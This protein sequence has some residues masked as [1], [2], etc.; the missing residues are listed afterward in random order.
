MGS[1]WEKYF[2]ASTNDLSRLFDKEGQLINAISEWTYMIKTNKIPHTES[3]KEDLKLVKTV[4]ELFKPDEWRFDDPLEYA[5]H[6]INAFHLLK[7]TSKLWPEMYEN[8]TSESLEN[9]F[10]EHIAH[11]P[12]EDDYKYGACVGM[13]NIELYYSLSGT[14]FLE[15]AKGRVRNPSN[16]KIYQARHTLTSN[17]FILIADAAWRGT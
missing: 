6:P 5:S 7:R 1:E 8:I 12:E 16:G 14:T 3:I 17:D 15:I 13:V 9:L 11:F 10:E 4:F 2:A